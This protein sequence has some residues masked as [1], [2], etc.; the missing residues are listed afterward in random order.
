MRAHDVDGAEPVPGGKALREMRSSGFWRWVA[1]CSYAGYAPIAPGTAGTAVTLPFAWVL[2]EIGSLPLSLAVI[3]VSY[4]V[5]VKAANVVESQLSEKDPSMVVIDE[6]VGMLITVVGLSLSISGFVL[7]FLLF[8]AMD[9]L[10]PFPG[11]RAESLPAGTGIMLD[12][13][14]AGIYAHLLMRLALAF[15]PALAS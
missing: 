5:G 13:V 4:F 11:R 2:Q 6:W 9:I 15:F 14:I 8:R 1:T 3:V 7:A 12:D 10:K